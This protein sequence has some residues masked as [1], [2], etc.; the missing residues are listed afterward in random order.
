[1]HESGKGMFFM[2]KNLA[3]VTFQLARTFQG[4]DNLARSLQGTHFFK[5]G[6]LKS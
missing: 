5:Q 2:T 1:M 3:R 4:N 6:M